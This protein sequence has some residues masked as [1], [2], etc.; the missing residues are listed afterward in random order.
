[1]DEVGDL[2]AELG[3]D[4]ERLLAALKDGRVK[5]FR[6]DKIEQLREFLRDEGALDPRPRLGREDLR[7]RVLD[8]VAV[9]VAAGTLSTAEVDRLLDHLPDLP[10]GD[11]KS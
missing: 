3:G 5:G 7:R 6:S 1:M 2:A 11:E 9:D 10:A 8:A 4:P